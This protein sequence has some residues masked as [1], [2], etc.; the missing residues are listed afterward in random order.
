MG[1]VSSVYG[2]R[3]VSRANLVGL[4]HRVGRHG[5]ADIGG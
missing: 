5:M 4:F 2:F 3:L 1:M